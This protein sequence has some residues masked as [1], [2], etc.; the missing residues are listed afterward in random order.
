MVEDMTD[1]KRDIR[2]RSEQHRDYLLSLARMTPEQRLD[3]AFE[4]SA[5]AKANL[6]QALLARFPDKSAAELHQL[7]LQRLERCRNRNY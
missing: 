5:L 6:K 4:L 3:K 7:F 2:I 1:P